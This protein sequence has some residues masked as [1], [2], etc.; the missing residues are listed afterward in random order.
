MKNGK[1]IKNTIELNRISATK[2]KKEQQNKRSNSYIPISY[3]TLQN[4]GYR[5]L[6]YRDF[7]AET[8]SSIYDI[9][10][11]SCHIPAWKK[12]I[13]RFS[14][15]SRCPSFIK[16]YMKRLQNTQTQF[17]L[18]RNKTICNFEGNIK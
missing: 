7:K 14:K 17:I 11:T 1:E 5:I 15:L 13:F 16:I 10:P 4:Y 3:S 9:I 6:S 2:L 8:N 18:V 12:K